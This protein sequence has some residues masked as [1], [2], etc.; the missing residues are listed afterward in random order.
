MPFGACQFRSIELRAHAYARLD[1]FSI[2][3]SLRRTAPTARLSERAGNPAGACSAIWS[4]ARLVDLAR[5]GLPVSSAARLSD[6]GNQ[7]PL[8]RAPVP[9]PV[10]PP[11]AARAR[12]ARWRD[13]SATK[14]SR[15]GLR[16]PIEEIARA[17]G[18]ARLQQVDGARIEHQRVCRRNTLRPPQQAL[19]FITLSSGL[20]PFGLLDQSLQQRFVVRGQPSQFNVRN[21]TRRFCCRPSSVSLLAMGSVSP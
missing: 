11:C 16:G 2:A 18:V 8:E 1:E 6:Q 19:R 17:R 9:A 10:P 12:A 4:T 3:A 20:G 21:T 13:S 15:I 14:D 7:V 5:P